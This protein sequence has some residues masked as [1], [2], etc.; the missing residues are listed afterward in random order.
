MNN[1]KTERIAVLDT[2]KYFT[3][4]GWIFTEKTIGDRGVDAD[5]EIP[6]NE[7]GQVRFF[8]L[9]I[10]GGK[11]QFRRTRD[12]LTFY[13]PERHYIYWNAVIDNKPLFIILQDSSSDVIYWQEYHPSNISKT[14]KN[15]KLDIPISNILN[16]DAKRTIMDIVY[17]N[18]NKSLPTVKPSPAPIQKVKDDLLVYFYYSEKKNASLYIILE[19]KNEIISQDL[20]YK[21]KKGEWNKRES[22]LSTESSHYYLTRN[23][24]KHMESIFKETKSSRKSF[25]ELESKIQTILNGDIR[26]AEEYL[27]DYGNKD[28]EIPKYK[29]FIRAFE[30]HTGLNASQYKV[31]TYDH[32]I[33]FATEDGFFEVNCD[34][35]LS[36][37]L[38]QLIDGRRYEEIL[39]MTDE[40]IWCD[41]YFE[42]G[43]EKYDFITTMQPELELYWKTKYEEI[44]E[45]VGCTE[46][47]DKMKEKSWREFNSFIDLYNITSVIELAYSIN[48]MELYPIAVIT[49]LKIYN[50]EFCYEEYCEREFYSKDN[51]W[52]SVNLGG[53]DDSLHFY[54]R[55]SE[56]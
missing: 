27:F 28:N 41:V 21:P 44:E 54:I 22:A 45:A 19:Y 30:L 39:T 10:K 14:S 42:P 56:F 38:K 33:H 2:A 26:N 15:W 52:E 32:S 48:A 12:R 17:G 20:F 49:M 7:S 53:N 11:S 31:N 13:F 36:A 3:E 23:L 55:P 35:G 5:V 9:Q 24:K 34:E 29:D 37:F 4:C 50:P 1:F 25:L 51:E 8:S 16:S 47:L 18:R 40:Q 6:L 46:H 43:I